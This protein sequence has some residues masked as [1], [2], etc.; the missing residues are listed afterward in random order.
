MQDRR[1]VRGAL[2]S[3]T[4]IE[5]VGEDRLDRAIG[6]RADVDRPRSRSVEALAPVGGGKPENAETG[7]EA[8]L[9]V[10]ALVENEVAQCAGCRDRKSTH[11]T[12]TRAIAPKLIIIIDTTLF[13]FTMPP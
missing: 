8:L 12:A 1:I 11:S 3:G 9:G 13:A 4:P 2:V 5:I 6:A 10:R 7:A